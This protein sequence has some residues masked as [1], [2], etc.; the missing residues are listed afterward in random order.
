[1]FKTNRAV[2]P[3]GIRLSVTTR[4]VTV[5]AS[6]YPGF[7]YALQTL[8]QLTGRARNGAVWGVPCV[9]IHDQPL[10]AWRGFMLDSGRQYQTVDE[11]K[12]CLDLMSMLK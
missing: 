10:M 8:R 11:I 2:A 1:V 6:S 5:E 4:K 9:N 7:V 12:H 3:E